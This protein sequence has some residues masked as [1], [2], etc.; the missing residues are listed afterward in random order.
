MPAASASDAHDRQPAP[1]A[2]GKHVL[3]HELQ[4]SV[5]VGRL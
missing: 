4:L 2:V 1:P 3:A 5:V